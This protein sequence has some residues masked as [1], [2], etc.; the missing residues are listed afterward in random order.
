MIGRRGLR[1]GFFAVAL[2]V[3][4]QTPAAVAEP[5]LAV[6]TGLKCA[7]CH[8]NRSGGG[9]RNAFGSVWAQTQLPM[10]TVGIR[11]RSLSDWV[12]IGLDLRTLGT[13][14]V[15]KGSDVE[16]LP[17]TAIEITDAQ[18]QL[19]ARFIDNKLALYVDQTLGPERAY[20][21]ELFGLVE[22]LPLNGYVKAGKFLLPYGWRLWDDGEFIREETGFKY[23]TPDLG[24][25]LGVEPGRLSWFVAL[26]NGSVGASEG[27]SGKMLSSTAVF[28]WP[29][30]RVGASAAYNQGDGAKTQLVGAYA[31]FSVGPLVILGEVDAVFGSF[32]D[33]NTNDRDGLLAF[34]EGD[35]LVRKGINLKATH[36]FHD[37]T[38]SI[39]SGVESVEEDQRARTRLGIETFPVSFVQLSAFYTRLDN[40]GDTRD[41]DQLSLELHLHF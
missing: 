13:W 31:G 18:V 16:E 30:F 19:E 32:D 5:H 24:V 41:V 6:R 14:N 27:N 25:E 1:L 39:R 34:V 3:S 11:S 2:S 22:Q 15:K 10:R 4:V 23:R 7:Q 33:A 9:G 40:A 28:T 35:L 12:S 29:G 8:V 17:T 38:A 36:G 26:T 21:R 37:P 20:S